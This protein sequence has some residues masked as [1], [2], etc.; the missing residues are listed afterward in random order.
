MDYLRRIADAELSLILEALVQCKSMD[1]N[2]V[3]FGPL[4]IHNRFVII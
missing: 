2:G 1:Q 3:E 4:S